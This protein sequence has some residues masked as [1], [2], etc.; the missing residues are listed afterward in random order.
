MEYKKYNGEW[1]EG[2]TIDFKGFCGSEPV[3]MSN[4]FVD[5]DFHYSYHIEYWRE[6]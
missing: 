3:E 6:V 5:E 4:V 1:L 2:L